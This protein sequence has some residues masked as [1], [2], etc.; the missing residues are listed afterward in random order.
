DVGVRMATPPIFGP[1]PPFLKAGFSLT[2]IVAPAAADLPAELYDVSL[3]FDWMRPI[4]DRWMMRLTFAPAYASDGKN[5]SSDAWQFRGAVLGIRQTGETLQ[6]VVGAVASGRRDFPVFPGAGAIWKPSPDFRLDLVFPQPRASWR[7]SDDGS[8]QQWL[9]V[10]GGISGGTWAYQRI[11]GL[12]EVLTYN[13]WRVLVGWQW[14][15][16]PKPGVALS[17]G[18]KVAVE[19]GYVFGREFEFDSPAPDIQ[20]DDTL[21]LRATFGF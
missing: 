9:Y 15:P 19:L 3:G 4:N 18:H 16:A 5:N 8:R 12:D 13:E 6:L 1:P 2:D 17:I 10:G 11:A 7:I 20:L 14:V 21:L